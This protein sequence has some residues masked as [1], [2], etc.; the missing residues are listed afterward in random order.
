MSRSQQ[1]DVGWAETRRLIGLDLEAYGAWLPDLQPGWPN[2][3]H[4][5]SV[6]FKA[7]MF[8]ANLLYRLQTFLYGARL[9]ALASVLSRLNHTFSLVSIGRDVRI[10]GGLHLVH[11]HLVVDGTTTLGRNVTIAPFVTIGL[12]NRSGLE[13]GANGPLVGDDVFIGTGAKLLGPIRVGHRARIGAN[14]VVIDDVPDD[15][16][17]VGVPARAHLSNAQRA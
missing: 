16:T 8:P 3:V 10:G 15:H 5:L 7:H 11:G 1:D 4:F 17:A 6:S 12:S 14:A 13:M 2:W 9:A